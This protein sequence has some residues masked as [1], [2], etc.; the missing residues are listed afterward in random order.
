VGE[1]V[2]DMR[3]MTR[4]KRRVTMAARRLVFT[5]VVVVAAAEVG[6]RLS[7]VG[8]KKAC[9]VEGKLSLRVRDGFDRQ[10]ALEVIG[11]YGSGVCHRCR[12]RNVAVSGD[13]RKLRNHDS[14]SCPNFH[15][16]TG[17]CND[18]K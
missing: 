7:G 13:T 14:Q 12:G 15:Q 3:A 1:G 18:F 6:G 16:I 9:A 4:R 2:E 8:E 5:I 10:P 17:I 11:E